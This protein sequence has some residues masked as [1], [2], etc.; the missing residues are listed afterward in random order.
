MMRPPDD[1]V[2]RPGYLAAGNARSLDPSEYTGTE[3][4]MAPEVDEQRSMDEIIDRLAAKYDV[5]PRERVAQVVG[6]ALASLQSA[7]VRDFVPVL[8]EREAKAILK[9]EAKAAKA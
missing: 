4:P 9:P 6:E 5:L 1:I 2:E 8:V 7:K 3:T